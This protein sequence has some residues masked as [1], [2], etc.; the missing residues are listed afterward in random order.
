MGVVV[1]LELPLRLLQN[2]EICD[3][4]PLNT[5]TASKFY[6]TGMTQSLCLTTTTMKIR[7]METVR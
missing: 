4:N 1:V 7:V 6:A 2:R 5:S 3:L